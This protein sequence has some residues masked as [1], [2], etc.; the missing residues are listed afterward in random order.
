M[1][2]KLD[3]FLRSVV[4]LLFMGLLS[5]SVSAQRTV[6]GTVTDSENGEPLIGATIIIVGTGQG[7]ITDFDGNYSLS[8]SEGAQLEISYA[9]Y[10]AQEV[11]V[12]ASGNLDVALLAGTV[13]DE[14]VV[15]GYG[16]QREKEVTSA[17]VSVGSEDFNQGPITDPAQLLQ[18]K[19]AGLQVYNRNGDPNGNASIRLRGLSTVGANVE[20]LI[21]V[22]GIIG[23]SLNNVDPA[24]IESIDVLKDGSAAA[25]YG[26]RGS[27]GVII[28]TTKK[29]S[30]AGGINLSYSGQVG[31]SNPVNGISVMNAQEF[32]AAGGTNLGSDVDWLDEVTRTGI[33]H[34]HNVSASG[35]NG[36][37]NYRI[38]GNFRGVDGILDNSGFDQFNTRVN[39]STRAFQDKLKVGFNTSFT[40]RESDFGFY[41]S[42]RYA[43][44]YN[45]TAPING[46]DSPFPFNSDQFGGFFEALGLFDSFNPKSI[47]EQNTNTGTKREFNYGLNLGYSI[48]DNLTLNVRVAQQNASNANR[49]YYPTTSLFRGNATSPTRKGRAD[50][51]NDNASFDLYE[52]YATHISD[53]GKTALTLTAGYSYQQNNFESTYMSL[54][55]FPNNDIDFIDAL[56][57]SQD[58]NNAGFININSDTS[59]D[60]K[61]IA[62]FGRANVT[63]DDAIF[64]NASVRR[65]GSTKLGEDNQWGIFPAFGV[66]VDLNN[67]LNI[68]AF[69]LLKLRVGYGVTG[70]LPQANG[71]SRAIRNVVNGS[72][73]SVSTELV[74]AAN[75]DLKWEEKAETN[76][77]IEFEAGKLGGTIDL[78]NRDISD[79]ILERNVDVAVYGVERRVENAGKLN[80]QGLE[81]ALNYDVVD[82]GNFAYNTGVVFSTYTTELEEFVL[83]AEMRGNLGSPGQNETEM[84]R[85][86]VGNEI[87]EI[88]GPVHLGVN[89]DGTNIFDDIN[90]DG[91]LLTDQA[92]ALD[93]DADYAVLGN[94]IPDFE[95]GWTNQLSVGGWNINAFFRGAFGH[96]LVNTFRA[97]YEPVVSTQSSYNFMNTELKVDGLTEARFSSL[98]VEKADFFRLDNLTISRSVPLGDVTAISN[99]NV[100]LTGQNLF[101]ITNYTGT[102]P[103]PALGDFGAASNG[104]SVNFASQD[105]LVPGIDRRNNYFSARTLT[106]GLNF[107]F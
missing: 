11:T 99:L 20:P 8:A 27:S 2:L 82:N 77:G 3:T 104:D 94:G 74:R 55:D 62:F 96:S 106:F 85:V 69:D 44:T 68:E 65:E 107:N 14:V 53:F 58:L 72:D 71:L 61:I 75:P 30:A 5:T 59:P 56:E 1:K 48:L 49:T 22:D 9:G 95:I 102:D 73:G 98:Y 87:G 25:I 41:E 93:P 12:G 76:I 60:E 51:Y 21:V 84:V 18:G 4:L 29:G 67:Y 64:L 91:N 90:G 101:T 66:G 16:S 43:V 7:T 26:S 105:P 86:K 31:A 80:T 36:V 6:S 92:S 34:V 33:T 89:D 32:V 39:I 103:D 23:A 83:D 28:V 50:I 54:G 10:T 42:L 47:I 57:T 97:F 63:F 37:T 79:F 81:V 15:V 19:V 40:N 52:A 35:G 45:P 100:S 88:W 78:Y 38:S 24:D 13:L 17:V 70:A 46:A